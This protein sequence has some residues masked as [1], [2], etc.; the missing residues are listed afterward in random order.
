VEQPPVSLAEA[1]HLREVLA[2]SRPRADEDF[3]ILVKFARR[4]YRIGQVD[5]NTPQVNLGDT[6]TARDLAGNFSTA[7]GGLAVSRR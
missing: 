4:M 5:P 6:L 3:E 7:T 2:G 1:E